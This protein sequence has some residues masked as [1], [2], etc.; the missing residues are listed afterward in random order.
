MYKNQFQIL[1]ATC[2][3]IIF[4]FRIIFDKTEP[5]VCVAAWMVEDF[6]QIVVTGDHYIGDSAIT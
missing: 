1:S 3:L 6:G 2:P 5:S 4:D